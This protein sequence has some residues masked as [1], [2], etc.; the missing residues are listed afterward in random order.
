MG[1]LP[2]FAFLVIVVR[3]LELGVRSRDLKLGVGVGVYFFYLCLCLCVR[4]CRSIQSILI[5]LSYSSYSGRTGRNRRLFVCGFR[6][7]Y[8]KDFRKFEQVN[9][10]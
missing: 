7:S 1:R 6:N 5:G 4:V 3:S 10:G 2:D 8:I 9:D